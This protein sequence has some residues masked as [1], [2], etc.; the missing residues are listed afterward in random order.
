M[1]IKSFTLIELIIVII[2]FGVASYLV[3]SSIKSTQTVITPEQFRDFKNK[4]IYLFRDGFSI[5]HVK[6]KLTNPIVYDKD[7][8]EIKFDRYND[9]EV[10]FKYVV[11]N[12]IQNSYILES[13]EG[14]YVFKPLQTIKVNSLKEAQKILTYS[15]YSPKE[16][17]FYR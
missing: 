15:D 9:K 8:K 16:G 3:T 1:R 7:L 5:K 2:I 6:I 11:H 12:G 17:S 10:I 14:I 4:T 13:N